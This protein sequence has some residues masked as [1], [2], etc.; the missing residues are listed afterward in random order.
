MYIILMLVYYKL[1]KCSP[2]V[3]K[4]EQKK[5][6]PDNFQITAWTVQTMAVTAL[7]PTVLSE[8]SLNSLSP[9]CTPGV[10][11][12]IPGSRALSLFLC[13]PGLFRKP[14]PGDS[15][16]YFLTRWKWGVS[17]RLWGRN[18]S[19]EPLP[20]LDPGWWPRA[21]LP[22]SFGRTSQMGS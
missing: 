19:A 22:P 20:S 21:Q 15:T 4:S 10:E 7:S 3:P 8:G 13:L 9:C 6:Q 2:W 17:F 12:G 11:G 18:S 14:K 1:I 16:T 5:Q